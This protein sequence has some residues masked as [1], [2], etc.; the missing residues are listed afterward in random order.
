LRD[1]GVGVLMAHIHPA[2]AASTSVAR[3]LGLAPTD[4]I[5]DGEVRWQGLPR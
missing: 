5:A 4:V 2:H 1:H 3:A